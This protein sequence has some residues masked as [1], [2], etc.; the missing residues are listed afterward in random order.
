MNPL[1]L[2][3]F[4]ATSCIGRGL[5]PTLQALREQRGGLAPCTFERA[6]LQTWVGA[7]DGVD[8]EPVRADLRAF[9]C[10]NHR[11]AQLAL[12]QDGFADAVAAAATRYGATRIGVFLG[13]S[14]SGILETEQA[15]RRRDPQSGALPVDFHYAQ[16]HN[17]YA[18]AAFVRA[19]FA[20]GGP[21]ASISSA[22]SS[23][24]KVFGSARR[25]IEAGLIDAAVVGGVDSLCLTTLYGF[26]SLELLSR[27]RCRPFDVARKGISIGEAAAFALLERPRQASGG[28]HA[29]LLLGIGESSDAHHMSSPHPEGLGAR[30]AIEGALATAGL[31]AAD[32]DYINL[33]GTATP[34]ND[35]AE[36][37]AVNALFDGT[38]S[39]STKGATGHTLGAA[40]AL[41]AVISALALRHQFVPAGIGTTEPDPALNLHYVLESRSA[42]LR[43]VLSNSF[44]FGGT[45]CSLILGR[46]D[47]THEGST[48]R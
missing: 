15:Y 6:E 4:T 8:D 40:G 25:M 13:T 29:I 39:S 36:S 42:P 17:C 31:A 21:A 47:I 37:L 12:R 22:C 33:H 48:G 30:R 45:N 18:L 14:T 27:E 20:L 24:A 5:G 44:G 34:G 9:D 26:N 23:G 10:R 38:P 2:T 35:T 19:Y 28:D 46:S 1:Q 41:E 3:H 43:A 7:V 32:I 11:L 16:T